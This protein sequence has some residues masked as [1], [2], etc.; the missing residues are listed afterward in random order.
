[1][2]QYVEDAFRLNVK[3]SLLE[4]SK[5]I[6]GDGKTTPNPLF[7]IKVVLQAGKNNTPTVSEQADGRLD[8]TG[9]LRKFLN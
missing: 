1:M 7:K 5:A 4:I 9:N 6:N 3:S 8:V 2:D